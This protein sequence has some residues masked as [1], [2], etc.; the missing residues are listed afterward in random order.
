METGECKKATQ[1]L[2]SFVNGSWRG[3]P[4]RELPERVL[5]EAKVCLLYLSWHI[6]LRPQAYN[7][8]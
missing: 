3:S 8:L 6:S 4:G 1:I 2:D 5:R 7:L